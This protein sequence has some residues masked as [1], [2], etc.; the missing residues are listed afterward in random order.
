VQEKILWVLASV[1]GIVLL[2]AA[3]RQDSD[4]EEEEVG[5]A[6]ESSLH[7]QRPIRVEVLNGCGIPQVAARLTKKSRALGLDVI[8]EGNAVDFNFL[9]TMVIDRSGDLEKARQVASVLGVPHCIQQ[10][11][12][13]AYR[14]ADVS[15]IIGRDYL[16]M[17]LLEDDE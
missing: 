3:L 16:Q 15:I 8:H 1:A 13:D 14:L 10:I 4:Q 11:T 12:Q 6:L 5:K 9:H 2:V 17:N 7:L